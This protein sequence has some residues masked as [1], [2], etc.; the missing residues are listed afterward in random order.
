MF[1][2]QDPKEQIRSERPVANRIVCKE[3]VRFRLS[4]HAQTRAKTYMGTVPKRRTVT[5]DSGKQQT[6]LDR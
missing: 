6:L 1:S 3:V 2:I 5:I 4:G